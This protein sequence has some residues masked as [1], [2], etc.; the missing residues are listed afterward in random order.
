[1]GYREDLAIAYTPEG[2]NA[3]LSEIASPHL[4]E[5]DQNLLVELLNEADQHYASND[6]CHF[7]L[8]ESRKLGCDDMQLLL[9]TVHGK[10]DD[11]NWLTVALGEDGCE[12]TQGQFWDNPFSMGVQR[13]LEFDVGGCDQQLSRIGSLAKK[14]QTI[15]AQ[16][17]TGKVISAPVNDHTCVCCG[18]TA[19]SKSE[20][21]CWK[22]GSQI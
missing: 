13:S 22:C 9:H 10:I 6:G 19:C 12:E 7:L 11:E 21:S 5:Y 1:M 3:L 18:N 17:C 14:V 8:F 15:T 4:C 2:W 16:P 20:K